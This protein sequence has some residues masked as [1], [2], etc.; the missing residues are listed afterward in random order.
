MPDP[1]RPSPFRPTLPTPTT[2]ATPATVTTTA[3][4]VDDGARFRDPVF[5]YASAIETQRGMALVRG[6]QGNVWAQAIH[7][8]TAAVLDAQ[9]KA[10]QLNPL[11]ARFYD[12][13]FPVPP[14]TTTP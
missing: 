8:G 6:I 9:W 2:P 7:T 12:G 11:T 4:T 10:L 5:Y 1:I 13:Q 14:P 3:Q